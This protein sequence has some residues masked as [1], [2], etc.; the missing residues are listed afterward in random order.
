M[1]Y[2]DLVCA[3]VDKE[4]RNANKKKKFLNVFILVYYEVKILPIKLT[5]KACGKA[6]IEI[7]KVNFIFV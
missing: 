6:K 1:L 7:I 4:K 5:S 2:S 3:S